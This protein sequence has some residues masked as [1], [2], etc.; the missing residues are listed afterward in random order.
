MLVCRQWFLLNRHRIEY[1]LVYKEDRSNQELTKT[2]LGLPYASK[3]FLHSG[4]MTRAHK[5]QQYPQ[6][7]R[8]VQAFK[9]KNE[10]ANTTTTQAS[11]SDQQYKQSNTAIENAN[12]IDLFHLPQPILRELI[13]TGNYNPMARLDPILPYLSH[14]TSLK[15]NGHG[16]Y[17]FP[18]KKVLKNCEHLQVLHLDSLLWWSLPSPWI[19]GLGEGSVRPLPLRKL[20]LGNTFMNWDDLETLLVFTPQL[21]ELIVVKREHRTYLDNQGDYD[22]SRLVYL[23]RRLSLPLEVFEVAIAEKAL[24]DTHFSAMVELC[25]TL[26]SVTSMELTLPR[27]KILSEATNIITTLTLTGSKEHALHWYLCQSPHLLHLRASEVLFT[28]QNLDI[29]GRLCNTDKH[30]MANPLEE[31][32]LPQ[33]GIWACRKLLTLHLS[34]TAFNAESEQADKFAEKGRVLFGY[35]SRVVPRLHDIILGM[36]TGLSPDEPPPMTLDAGLCLLSRLRCLENF[37]L[38]SLRGLKITSPV[39]LDWMVGQG[40]TQERVEAR[41]ELIAE[42]EEL[43]IEEHERVGIARSSLV[44]KVPEAPC[45]TGP[46]GLDAPKIPQKCADYDAVAEQLRDLGYLS[47]VVRVIMEMDAQEDFVCW[48]FVKTCHIAT[49]AADGD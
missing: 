18:M 14:L 34:F 46:V 33:P 1:T 15:I 19:H 42:W 44:R 40:H 2:L 22:H 6:R 28:I 45:A 48:P 4:K 27:F 49:N 47:D 32:V 36:G 7:R 20:Y 16:D 39:D 12:L 3:F 17:S 5:K 23:L 41:Q 25:P 8:L 10:S 26:A 21:T 29:N 38:H 43:I 11:S 13:I 37:E 31:P 35:L 24:I 9:V 30:D